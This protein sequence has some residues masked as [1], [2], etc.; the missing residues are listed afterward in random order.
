MTIAALLGLPPPTLP[1][2]RPPDDLP[3]GFLGGFK[4]AATST[5]CLMFAAD[6]TRFLNSVGSLVVLF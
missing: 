2:R 1:S 4:P 3:T 6:G 5:V